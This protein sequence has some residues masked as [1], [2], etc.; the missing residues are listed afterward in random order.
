V[1][2][3]LGSI[4]APTDFAAR[5]TLATKLGIGTSTAPYVGSAEQ[6][7]ALL[8]AL[9][10]G[11]GSGTS[12]SATAGTSSQTS[13]ALGGAVSSMVGV[14]GPAGTTGTTG[15]TGSTDTSTGS[16]VVA[17]N[18]YVDP[19]TGAFD[20][21][22][23]KT[24]ATADASSTRDAVLA[25]A[26]NSYKQGQNDLQ[27]QMDQWT[28]TWQ[29]QKDFAIQD[30]AKYG[31]SYAQEVSEHYDQIYAQQQGAFANAKA[32][33][34]TNYQNARLS[35]T[36]Q[37]DQDQQGIV[38]NVANFGMSAAQFQQTQQNQ[39]LTQFKTLLAQ[40]NVDYTNPDAVGNM[41]DDEVL[42][43][44]GA[45]VDI[46][47]KGGIGYRDAIQQIRNGLW[48]QAK[49]A[50]ATYQGQEKVDIAQISASNAA[51]RLAITQDRLVLAQGNA[52]VNRASK[53]YTNFKAANTP[54]AGLLTAATYMT[55]MEAGYA[56]KGKGPSAL[57]MLDAL[58][59]MDT[60]GQA[61]RQG[62]L[63]IIDKAGTFGDTL[64]RLF[65]KTNF[66]W[67]LNGNA[68]GQDVAL[69]PNQVEQIYSVAK[70]IAK[71]KIAAGQSS[72]DAFSTGVDSIAADPNVDPDQVYGAA[73]GLA[74][75]QS[76]IAKYGSGD[77]DAQT[78]ATSAGYDY[79]AMVKAGYTDD[80]ILSA[81]NGK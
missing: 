52:A 68:V 18:D 78:A 57:S 2:N 67:D 54:G 55:Q 17:T 20:S 26:D 13:S 41:T 27:T 43:N 8:A 33:L 49:A 4:G 53:L 61:I 40:T 24:A 79:N 50:A 63:D 23:Y 71:E 45:L 51:E 10:K 14:T 12:T 15:T 42:K 22:A 38:A 64:K 30:A 62:Q 46:A 1:V 11:Q 60:N 65:D 56:N 6:N 44:Y 35:A 5:S 3:Y 9:R 77:S 21:S 73:P 69:S 39:A 48:Q 7:T 47:V 74:A 81:I 34:N 76:F 16:G 32:Q 59:K 80:Q 75:A 36:A 37:Y 28:Q 70:Q 31:G 66:S 25:E 72:F 29:Q 19:N 58:V